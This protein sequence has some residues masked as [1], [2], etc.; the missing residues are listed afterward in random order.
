L[1]KRQIIHYNHVGTKQHTDR[2]RFKSTVETTMSDT[3]KLDL[4]QAVAFGL[5]EIMNDVDYPPN[6]NV[7]N[8]DCDDD[9]GLMVAFSAWHELQ[10]IC[11]SV[12]NGAQYGMKIRF[13]H[14]LVMTFLFR[15][16]VPLRRKLETIFRMTFQHMW[17]LAK[18]AGVYKVRQVKFS[19]IQY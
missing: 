9:A 11:E 6:T 7:T 15:R 5:G 17:S 4:G 8:H 16:E 3:K 14:A 12:F 13:P 18:F 1:G 2:K 19:V 10:A